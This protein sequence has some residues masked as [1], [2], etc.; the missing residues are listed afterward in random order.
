MFDSSCPRLSRASTS[1]FAPRAESSCIEANSVRSRGSG[2]P[3]L[4]FKRWVSAFAV[5][6]ARFNLKQRRALALPPSP[7]QL[8]RDGLDQIRD[9]GALAGL[10]EG[11]NRHAGNQLEAGEAGNLMVRERDPDGV[12]A[13]SGLLILGDIRRDAAHFA[14]DLR[15][16]ALI[17]RGKAQHR[18][19]ADP[20]LV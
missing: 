11:F 2:S 4:R 14:V 3:V 8:I 1:R 10:D 20:N 17:E 19:L 16:R 6:N 13:H 7:H 9:R 12:E 15:R 5:T 18:A